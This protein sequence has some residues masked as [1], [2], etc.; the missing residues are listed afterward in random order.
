MSES[1][2]ATTPP[3]RWSALLTAAEWSAAVEAIGRDRVEELHTLLAT[4]TPSFRR[5]FIAELGAI[6][7][8]IPEGQRVL[9][10]IARAT[11]RPAHRQLNALVALIDG[12]AA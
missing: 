12:E 3:A 2:T 10:A 1:S 11:R 4:V 6:R 8:A 7:G 9:L 5:R